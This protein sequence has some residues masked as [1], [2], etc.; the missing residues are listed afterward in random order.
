M[1]P[2]RLSPL[3]ESYIYY[4]ILFRPTSSAGDLFPVWALNMWVGPSL[5]HTPSWPISIV[6]WR[7]R[8]CVADRAASTT[9]PHAED[10][11]A[12]NDDGHGEE[13]A[14]L[15]RYG[16]AAHTREQKLASFWLAVRCVIHAPA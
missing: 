7:C 6:F 3:S 5:A 4:F 1:I 9:E 13:D 14:E 12:N 2:L 10:L 15:G 11:R 16:P 8:S